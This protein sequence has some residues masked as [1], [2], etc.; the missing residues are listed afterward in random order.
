MKMKTQKNPKKINTMERSSW[1]PQCFCF[2]FCQWQVLAEALADDGFETRCE[3]SNN[4][5]YAQ[6]NWVL[7]CPTTFMR[8]VQND[9][10]LC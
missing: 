9:L 10:R 8:K 7:Y 4:K 5:L 1:L 2:C 6:D 3:Q